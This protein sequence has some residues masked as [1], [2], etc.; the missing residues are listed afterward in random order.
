MAERARHAQ[1]ER[2]MLTRYWACAVT[3]LLT[4]GCAAPA[5]HATLG[6]QYLS[7]RAY[8]RHELEAA[9]VNP[10]DGYAQLRL[11]HYA[12]GLDSDWDNLP[13]WNP[14]TE[15]VTTEKAG[16]GAAPARLLEL[17]N[18]EDEAALRAF[19]KLAFSRY[20]AQL[21]P[22][23]SVALGSPEAAAQ[24]GLWL[25]EAR[26]V[27][28]LVRVHLADGSLT[29]A[30]TCSTC[31]A[32][33]AATGVEDGGAN[34]ALDLGAA[35]VAG[36][37]RALGAEAAAHFTAWG[38]GRLDVTTQSGLEPARI[39]DLRAE[40]FQTSLQQDATLLL[41]SETTLA[42]R[43]E[44]LLITSSGQVVRPPRLVALALAAYI[45]SLAD[46]LPAVEVAAVASADGARVFSA[47]CSFCHVP[48][49]LS[50]PA[51]PLD[52]VGTDEQLG[53]SADR[54]TGTYRVPSLRGVG[55][56]G[57]LLHDGSLPSLAT[58]FDPAREASTFTERLHG[59]G[60]VNGHRFGLDL[61]QAERT[62]LVDYLSLL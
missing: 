37:A 30:L 3:W 56:R 43:I 11:T 55:T 1:R 62:A 2:A 48:P 49:T 22:Y 5:S 42:I 47:N 4:V 53:L 27:G 25:D 12:T 7:D 23:L 32:A 36:S 60:P 24:Y 26:G 58:M 57:P 40:R 28:G 46:A 8:R 41:R 19:G 35:I 39:A 45:N 20:P 38:P 29:L 61:K 50:G 59:A 15:V 54:G 31:H 6:Q 18:P 52:V 17:P 16:S 51:I 9:L 34:A 13:E 44:T 14:E 33:R 10:N 21:A